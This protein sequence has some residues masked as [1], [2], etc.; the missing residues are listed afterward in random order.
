MRP[1][2]LCELI[3][4]CYDGVSLRAV[5][6]FLNPWLCKGNVVYSHIQFDFLQV[7]R[8]AVAKGIGQ[9]HFLPWSVLDGDIVSL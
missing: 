6:Q 3:H 9:L 4:R 5:L 1:A 8:W 2:L 7:S